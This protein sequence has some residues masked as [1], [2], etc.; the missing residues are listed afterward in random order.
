MSFSSFAQPGQICDRHFRSSSLSSFELYW[1]CQ[2]RLHINQEVSP[3]RRDGERLSRLPKL[4]TLLITSSIELTLSVW[5]IL[6]KVRKVFHPKY[7]SIF[8]AS[9]FIWCRF[10][11]H[12]CQYQSW[13]CAA[14]L[15]NRKMVFSAPLKSFCLTSGFMP[16][17]ISKN[18]GCDIIV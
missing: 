9:I 16:S 12:S 17:R 10:F 1:R 15:P 4:P 6:L 7:C 3:H 5:C 8:S 13:I 11:C 14:N 2:R 18:E